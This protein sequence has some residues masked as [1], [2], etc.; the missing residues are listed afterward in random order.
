MVGTALRAVRNDAPVMLRW[1]FIAARSA[2][3]PYRLSHRLAR[4]LQ[5]GANVEVLPV[6]NWQL[7]DGIGYWQQWQHSHAL[8]SA[9]HLSEW[10]LSPSGMNVANVKMLPIPMLPVSNWALATGT[11]ATFPKS[12]FARWR[13]SGEFDTRS[14]SETAH[15]R[16]R[17]GERISTMRT[18][19]RA[20]PIA[21]QGGA[22]RLA[23]PDRLRRFGAVPM[24]RGLEGLPMSLGTLG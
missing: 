23:E 12:L 13:F 19:G 9:G 15:H 1:R 21:P 11:M 7:V 22:R 6:S 16:I 24:R 8:V 5:Y 20:A 4:C 3:A 2:S 18:V 10:G 17:L 14:R